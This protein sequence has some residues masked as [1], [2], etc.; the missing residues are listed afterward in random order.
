MHR[1]RERHTH[2]HTDTV[3]TSEET[4]LTGKGVQEQM[5]WREGR[6]R[7]REEIEDLYKEEGKSERGGL[8]RKRRQLMKPE[9]A[10]TSTETS[11]DDAA[12]TFKMLFYF[13]FS[14]SSFFFQF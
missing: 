5:R 6:S 10:P 13:I 14:L 11:T 9:P 1:E 7:D 4:C 3:H 12:A 8:E 2:T